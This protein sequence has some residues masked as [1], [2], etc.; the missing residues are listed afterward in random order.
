MFLHDTILGALKLAQGFE[1]F[2]PVVARASQYLEDK[3]I[4]SPQSIERF[5]I[6]E[7]WVRLKP[8]R[9][10]VSPADN[11]MQKPNLDLSLY[12]RFVTAVSELVDAAILFSAAAHH[13]KVCSTISQCVH[14]LVTVETSGW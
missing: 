7:A 14:R 8:S 4:D 5:L 3:I 2:V 9:I 12:L 6:E 1:L 13:T 11:M 10:E